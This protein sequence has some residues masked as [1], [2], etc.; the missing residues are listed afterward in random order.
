MRDRSHDMKNTSSCG[1]CLCDT[2][3]HIRKSVSV[4]PSGPGRRDER[5][6][7]VRSGEGDCTTRPI[8]L[9]RPGGERLKRVSVFP[10]LKPEMSLS[11]TQSPPLSAGTLRF[12]IVKA[13]LYAQRSSCYPKAFRMAARHKHIIKSSV[14][15]WLNVFFFTRLRP[16]PT[17]LFY[18]KPSPSGFLGDFSAAVRNARCTVSKARNH[19]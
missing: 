6:A 7:A 2:K 12:I 16:P 3:S 15:R 9:S 13:G 19:L 8:Q 5:D 4:I 1:K 17:P 18:F 10:G 14:V 11:S